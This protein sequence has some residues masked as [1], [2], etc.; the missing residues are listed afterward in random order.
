M[1]DYVLYGEPIMRKGSHLTEENK[2][3]IS[4]A[5]KG[6]K[7]SEEHKQKIREGNIGIK[8]CLETRKRISESKKGHLVSEKVREKIREANI[9]NKYCLGR[10]YSEETIKKMSE[11]QSGSKHKNWLGGT[12]HGPYSKDCTKTLRESIRKRDN[13]VCQECGTK[14][15]NRSLDVHHIDYNR[16]NSSE[17]NLIT[18]CLSCH[19]KTNYNRSKWIKHFGVLME[20]K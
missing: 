18:L 2:L 8:R 6:K 16:S 14:S 4:L 17:Q 15:I 12:S 13:Y 11:A 9:G 7:L 1:Y 5:H 10:K 19:M 3:K 20:I